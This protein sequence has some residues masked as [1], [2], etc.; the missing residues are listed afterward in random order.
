MTQLTRARFET[1]VEQEEIRVSQILTWLSSM[2][3]LF[4]LGIGAKSLISGHGHHALILWLFAALVAVNMVVF[5]R[6]GNRTRQ[7]TGMILI[8]AL[9]FAYLMASGGESN[10]GPLWFY[11]FP[12]LLFYLTDLRTGTLLLLGCL[13]FAAVVFRFPQLPFVLAEYSNDFQLRFFATITF[14]SIFCYVLEASRRKARN[15]LVGLA[16]MH[17]R[18][19]RTDELTGLANRRDIHQRLLAEFGRYQRSG[20]HF[21]VVLI[22]LDLF[23]R[24]NDEYSHNAGDAV[25]KQFADLM[26]SVLRQA[27]LPAR[28]GGEEFLVLLPDTSL[29]Q[30]LTLAERLREAVDETPFR[31]QDRRLPVT[32]SAGVC[33]ISQSG[34]IDQLLRQADLNLYEAKQAGRNRIAPRVR[35]RGPAQPNGVPE[36]GTGS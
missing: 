6:T 8:V 22:D 16:I 20:H 19:A 1:A 30:A 35:S 23:K 21:S 9:L 15:E 7:K 29:V 13:A 17:E 11:V 4:L 18:A 33:S 14:E 5:W 3:I 10:T 31:Y 26:R 34:S 27:D 12:P 2:A 25:L 36:P 24:I 28:W 32:I